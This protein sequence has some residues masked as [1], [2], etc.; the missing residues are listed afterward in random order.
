MRLAVVFTSMTLCFIVS[1]CSG[2]GGTQTSGDCSAQVR[3]DGVVYTSHGYT[4]RKASKHSVADRADCADVGE[5]AVGSVFGDHPKQVTT[6]SFRGYP[7]EEVVGVRFDKDS[8]AVFV[9]DSVPEA[10]R[11][12]IYRELDQPSL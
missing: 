4:D 3:V 10:K 9:A 1:G 5:D 7:P 12:R 11:E 2:D 6:W 8:F